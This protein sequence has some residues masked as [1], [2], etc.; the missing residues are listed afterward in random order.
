MTKGLAFTP[1]DNS[2]VALLLLINDSSTFQHHLY[3]SQQPSKES[4]TIFTK[5]TRKL[6]AV[7]AQEPARGPTA[8]D[9]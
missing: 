5:K 1:P 3:S 6:K 7:G 9:G 8:A 4:R 2:K